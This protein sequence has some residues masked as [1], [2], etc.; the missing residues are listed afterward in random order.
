MGIAARPWGSV[1]SASDNWLS[2][3]ACVRVCGHVSTCACVRES[4]DDGNGGTWERVDKKRKCQCQSFTCDSRDTR[5]HTSARILVSL[6][7]IA[8]PSPCPHMSCLVQ[9]GQR[10]CAFARQ[11]NQSLALSS[12]PCLRPTL[13]GK[14]RLLFQTETGSQQQHR[15]LSLSVSSVT[16][17]PACHRRVIADAEQADRARALN[18]TRQRHMHSVLRHANIRH[19]C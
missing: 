4:E 12:R 3:S 19:S 15:T 14:R 11:C 10:D 18:S 13:H 2:L 7:F 1:P 9:A 5:L 17:S 16:L 8:L 6:R